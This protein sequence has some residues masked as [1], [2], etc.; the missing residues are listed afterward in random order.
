MIQRIQTF[1]LFI[2]LILLLIF[3]FTPYTIFNLAGH[4]IHVSVLFPSSN[5]FKTEGMIGN[6]I[7]AFFSGMAAVFLLF[8]IFLYKNRIR[9]YRIGV[10]S[11]ISILLIE[12]GLVYVLRWGM[13]PSVIST[14]QIT[15]IFP[16]ISL[17]FIFLALRAIKKDEEL[18]RSYDRIR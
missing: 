17:I 15:S 5:G 14:M 11:I 7:I 3:V 9:Q 1:Y 8:A 6:V 10:I 4:T 12:L 18:V 16:V 2:A 13:N